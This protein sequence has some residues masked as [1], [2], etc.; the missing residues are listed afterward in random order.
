MITYRTGTHNTA[1]IAWQKIHD[2]DKIANKDYQVATILYLHKNSWSR[3]PGFQQAE[4]QE[5]VC[6]AQYQCSLRSS[7]SQHYIA[8]PAFF[9]QTEMT[10]TDLQVFKFK[11][12]Q[13]CEGMWTMMYVW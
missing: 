10:R 5:K 8:R 4:A 9:N 1:P 12:H 3:T 2:K 13:L 11:V 7:H 6:K